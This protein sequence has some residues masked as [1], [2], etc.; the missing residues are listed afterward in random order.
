MTLDTS[1]ILSI[2]SMETLPSVSQ[3]NLRETWKILNRACLTATNQPANLF[4][5]FHVNDSMI[6]RSFKNM[7]IAKMD[8]F[9]VTA[10]SFVPSR[11]EYYCI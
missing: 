7:K 2:R 5:F 3:I 10:I 4:D 1:S 9:T 6:T 8:T 11:K